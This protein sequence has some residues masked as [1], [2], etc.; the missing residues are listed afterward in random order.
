VFDRDTRCASAFL[1]LGTAR[2]SGVHRGGVRH[3]WGAACERGIPRLASALARLY[4]RSG[5]H[6]FLSDVAVGNH[7]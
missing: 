2:R 4:L 5:W 6:G 7:R 1:W 3:C